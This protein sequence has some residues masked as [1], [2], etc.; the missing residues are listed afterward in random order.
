MLSKRKR[1]NSKNLVWFRKEPG[2]EGLKM[3]LFK[4]RELCFLYSKSY[5]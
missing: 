4:E 3:E 5:R 2:L 1:G